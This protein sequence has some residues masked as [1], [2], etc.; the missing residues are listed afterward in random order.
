M[1][2]TFAA[3]H[4]DLKL[5]ANP[6]QWTDDEVLRAMALYGDD[7]PGNLVVG[8]GAFERCTRWG[9]AG[10]RSS[11]LTTTRCWLTTRCRARCPLVGGGE[12]PVL[13]LCGRPACHREVFPGGRRPGGQR[14][15]DLLCANTW[16]C[17]RWPTQAPLPKPVS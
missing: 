15:W 6:M 1:G 4:P 10:P 3:A 5:S 8:E 2:R 13:R 9:S 16:R 14:T 12:Q 17:K 7:L 11:P